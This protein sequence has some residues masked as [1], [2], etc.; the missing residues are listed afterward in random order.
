MYVVAW[1]REST[2]YRLHLCLTPT[3]AQ[4]QV[5]R[6]QRNKEY[7]ENLDDIHVAHFNQFGQ[8]RLYPFEED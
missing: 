7:D 5:E 8:T 1:V 2:L 4:I 6:I 3:Q